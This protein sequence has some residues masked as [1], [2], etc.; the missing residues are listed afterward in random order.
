MKSSSLSAPLA[1]QHPISDPDT[2]ANR[3]EKLKSFYPRWERKPVLGYVAQR[4]K[5]LSLLAEDLARTKAFNG[6]KVDSIRIQLISFF[7]SPYE[8]K[9]TRLKKIPEALAEVF[10]ATPEELFSTMKEGFV[11]PPP[12]SAPIQPS[13]PPKK[14]SLK[15]PKK[16]NKD[17]YRIK[18]PEEGFP[19]GI[20]D[21]EDL[22]RLAL[23]NLTWVV[24]LPHGGASLTT[25]Q[26][27]AFMRNRTG[28]GNAGEPF[29]DI[30]KAVYALVRH[31]ATQEGVKKPLPI[32]K[33]IVRPSVAIDPK[34]A[35]AELTQSVITDG[36]RSCPEHL[37]SLIAG[38]NYNYTRL[39]SR[40]HG[41]S[42]AVTAAELKELIAEWNPKRAFDDTGDYTKPAKA[43]Y[44]LIGNDLIAQ[45]KTPPMIEIVFGA[46]PRMKAVN[47]RVFSRPCNHG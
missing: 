29:T 45:G 24:A 21:L 15:P 7:K 42:L 36:L 28:G 34:P 18:I 17:D 27:E 31:Y 35:G 47:E 26:L 13:S 14:T 38:A 8:P 25:A 46:S 37:K 23:G 6:T 1:H 12:V 33:V 19:D 16:R 11:L 9:G 10:G 41:C 40:L 20:E 22:V 39:A 4:Y 44:F 3:W 32:E 2:I 30:E 43:A 5:S